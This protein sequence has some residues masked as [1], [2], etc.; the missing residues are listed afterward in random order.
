MSVPITQR[1]HPQFIFAVANN[2]FK[3]DI[4]FRNEDPVVLDSTEERDINEWNHDTVIR[5]PQ[6]VWLEDAQSDIVIAEREGL[7]KNTDY[8]QLL[9]YFIIRSLGTDETPTRYLTY[10]RTSKVGE[11]KLAGNGSIGLGGHVDITDI[12][13]RQL[14][15]R[16]ELEGVVYIDGTLRLAAMREMYEEVGLDINEHQVTSY[17]VILDDSDD[18][19][20]VGKVHVALVN[21]IDVDQ[22]TS[23]T[24]RCL[25]SE[26][27]T[28]GFLT[29]E[30]LLDQTTFMLEPWTRELL[31]AFQE[32]VKNNGIAL[33]AKNATFGFSDDVP[34]QQRE[35]DQDAAQDI[36]QADGSQKE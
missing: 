21:I 35:S 26:L 3:R 36:Q 9:P 18:N 7:E 20:G 2:F 34:L 6:H 11:Q 24:L 23:D 30:E 16:P 29:V 8:R 25:E 31:H 15:G 33:S 28:V 17:G 1:K 10:R 14:P 4:R 19:K 13:Y 27:E 12:A 5:I 22:N 32:D